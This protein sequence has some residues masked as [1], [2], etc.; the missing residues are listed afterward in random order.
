VRDEVSVMSRRERLARVLWT[1][2]L[3]GD[4]KAA[5]LLV[6]AAEGR[7]LRA[8]AMAI[9]VTFTAD[10]YARARVRIRTWAEARGVAGL[11]EA[12]A[13]AGVETAPLLAL[14]AGRED[15]RA[16]GAEE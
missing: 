13:R 12:G 4:L 15:E 5:Q 8:L 11:L 10:D 14:E 2:A 9:G 1:Q 3:D 6:D 16:E 7:S